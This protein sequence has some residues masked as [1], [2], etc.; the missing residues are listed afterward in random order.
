MRFLVMPVQVFIG[1]WVLRG[2][3]CLIAEALLYAAWEALASTREMQ[4]LLQYKTSFGR[5]CNT[6]N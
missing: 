2:G 5:N 6:I 1:E 4:A 3:N